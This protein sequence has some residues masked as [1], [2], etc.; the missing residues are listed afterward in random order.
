M[1]RVPSLGLIC[2]LLFCAILLPEPAFCDAK[3]DAVDAAARKSLHKQS[4]FLLDTSIIG[5]T[6][7]R[8]T[9]GGDQ[10]IIND[11]TGNS[12]FLFPSAAI[13]EALETMLRESYPDG[14]FIKLD[15]VVVTFTDSRDAGSGKNISGLYIDENTKFAWA[16][17]SYQ[18]T[19][20]TLL[21]EQQKRDEQQKK[22]IKAK[23]EQDNRKKNDPAHARELQAKNR[24]LQQK[25][26][27]PSPPGEPGN[28]PGQ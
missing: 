2:I 24:E 19:Y 21:L 8:H 17:P 7:I 10:F 11:M 26:N 6:L 14:T 25:N 20:A 16:D 9:P 3:R 27:P 28:A 22:T 1:R 23:Q 13:P 5:Y 15:G 12:Y 18:Q 4:K